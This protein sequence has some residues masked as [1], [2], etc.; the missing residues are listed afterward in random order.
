VAYVREHDGMTALVIN[1]LSR[2][3]QPAS[4]DL[5]EFAGMTPVE[6]IGNHPFPSIKQEPYFLSLSP[7]AFF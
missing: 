5:R 1:N 6:M 2:F 3:A 4:L 7:H